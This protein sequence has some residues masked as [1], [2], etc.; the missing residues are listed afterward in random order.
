MHRGRQLSKDA[1]DHAPCA[2]WSSA[3]D[4][5]L[6]FLR[7][8]LD[9]ASAFQRMSCPSRNDIYQTRRLL[10]HPLWP[11]QPAKKTDPHAR[12]G[13]FT[14]LRRA[15]T[16]LSYGK[17]LLHTLTALSYCT[18]LLHTLTAHSYLHALTA[19]SYCTLLSTTTCNCNFGRY[20]YLSDFPGCVLV[21][22]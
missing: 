15:F 20:H 14:H 13:F 12:I 8:T 19:L 21:W 4:V 9:M 7:A 3:H 2:Y 16:A 1:P 22:R 17:L 5:A 6:L 11:N 10:K 18:L